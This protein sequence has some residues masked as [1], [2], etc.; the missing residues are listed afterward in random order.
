MC[1]LDILEL[2]VSF[3]CRLFVAKLLAPLKTGYQKKKLYTI[4]LYVSIYKLHY[5]VH[6]R[7]FMSFQNKRY[8]W[9]MTCTSHVMVK[10]AVTEKHLPYH[11]RL[12]DWISTKPQPS[13]A[14]SPRE[15]NAG[16]W[17]W[18]SAQVSLS[19]YIFKAL[20]QTYW[21]CYTFYIIKH[22]IMF[23]FPQRILIIL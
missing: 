12:W 21:M 23:I 14:R 16:S 18:S 3:M 6:D 4:L 13:I 10:S 2:F 17:V 19:G 20:N 8:S 11:P 1:A 15:L 5:F 9:P 22:T 7:S